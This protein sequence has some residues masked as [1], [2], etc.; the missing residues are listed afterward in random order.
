MSVSVSIGLLAAMVLSGDNGISEFVLFIQ[1]NAGVLMS[2]HLPPSAQWLASEGKWKVTQFKINF[3]V[4]I[5]SLIWDQLSIYEYLF[6]ILINILMIWITRRE[7]QH[8][9]S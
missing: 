4:K 6:K 9:F 7:I 5:N 2:F 1:A 8:T 3:E